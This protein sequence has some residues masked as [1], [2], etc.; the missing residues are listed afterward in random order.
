MKEKILRK[1]YGMYFWELCSWQESKPFNEAKKL[2]LMWVITLI[3]YKDREL[4]ERIVG[5]LTYNDIN[6]RN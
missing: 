2:I 4:C 3:G 5:S 1:L 6:Q